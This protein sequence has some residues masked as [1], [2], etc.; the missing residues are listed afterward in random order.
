MVSSFA[1]TCDILDERFT[2]GQKIHRPE[3]M[4]SGEVVVQAHQHTV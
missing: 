4:R 3:I 1:E 2:G